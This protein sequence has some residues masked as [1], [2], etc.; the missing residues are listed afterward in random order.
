MPDDD[1]YSP[2]LEGVI[3]A[4]TAVSF[5][6]GPDGLLYRGYAIAD[7]VAGSSFDD[8]AHLLIHGALPDAKQAAEFAERLAA[9]R[10]LPDRLV[11]LMRS[12]DPKTPPMDALRTTIS[13][14]AHFDPETAD[15]SAPALRRKAERLMG[16]IPS[17]M[18]VFHALRNGRTP[19]VLT[20]TDRPLLSTAAACLTMLRD[21]PAD[22][23]ETRDM[24]VS[25]TLYAEHE[26]N[27]STFAARV[28]A[29]TLSDLHSAVVAA[30]GA[31]KGPLHGGANEEVV[32]MLVEIGPPEAAEAWVREAL[33]GR[34][35]IMGF[36]HRVL[37]DGDPR[38]VILAGPAK[39]R[40]EATGKSDMEQSAAIVE[41]MLL[42]EKGLRPNL[43]WPAGRLYHYLGLDIDLFTPLFCASRIAGWSAHVIE[44]LGN[45]RLMR[46]R[47]RYTGPSRRPLE[48]K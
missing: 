13:A 20:R 41:R 1:R 8:V 7:L 30:V 32:R 2:G 43:D 12:L 4:E 45:N 25:L 42:A 33:A 5:V 21:K 14:H 15:N 11:L 3:A 22:D 31:L 39:R 28:V 18:S 44:Q 27:A 40:A 19:H 16:A 9:A 10:V 47:G 37:K 26:L 29:S 6:G 35:R 46:P 23:G 34:K 48:R 38:A 36:G 24:D 17:L